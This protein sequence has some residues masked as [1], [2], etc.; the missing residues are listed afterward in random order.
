MTPAMMD[1]RRPIAPDNHAVYFFQKKLKRICFLQLFKYTYLN[2]TIMKNILLFL[3]LLPLLAG[4]GGEAEG[5]QPCSPIFFQTDEELFPEVV[6]NTRGK[7]VRVYFRY[8]SPGIKHW[9]VEIGEEVLSRSDQ[10]VLVPCSLTDIYKID[11]LEV[12]VSGTVFTGRCGLIIDPTVRYADPE[13]IPGCLFEIS[14]IRVVPFF[15]SQKMRKFLIVLIFHVATAQTKAQRACG[16]E[17]SLSAIW[18]L[19]LLLYP[20]STPHLFALGARDLVC[21]SSNP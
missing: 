7:I 2:I 16:S 8:P 21:H 3:T 20:L 1:Q 9:T 17:L 15:T 5:L 19:V 14:D 18:S 10:T 13:S 11:R 4:C 12:I 6:K